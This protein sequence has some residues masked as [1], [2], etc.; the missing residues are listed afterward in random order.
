MKAFLKKRVPRS[1]PFPAEMSK[2]IASQRYKMK[3]M[4][5]QRRD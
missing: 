2:R 1:K 4:S 3:L 5:I